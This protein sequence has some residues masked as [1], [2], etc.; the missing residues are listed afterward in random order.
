[1]CE[2]LKAKVD[3]LTKS[4]KKIHKWQKEFRHTFGQPKTWFQ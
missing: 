3:Y 2:I 1:M 4:L